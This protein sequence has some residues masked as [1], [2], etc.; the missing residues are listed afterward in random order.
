MLVHTSSYSQTEKDQMT[1]M[2]NYSR[3]GSNHVLLNQLAGTWNFQDAKLSF[4]KGTLVRTAIFDGRFFNVEM[5]GGELPLPVGDGKMKMGHYKCL[6]IEGYDNPRMEF[7]TTSINNHIGS[8]IQVQTGTYNSGKKEFTY[9]WDSEALKGQI[10]SNRRV[11]R[12][13]DSTHY[14]ETYFELHSGQYVKVRELDF[15]RSG[16]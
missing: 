16:Q 8:D 7:F 12:I 10:I 13:V 11:V 4:V 5:T 15:T 2:L 9:N 1:Q 14:V 3:P 6:Q